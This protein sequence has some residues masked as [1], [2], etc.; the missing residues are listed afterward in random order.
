MIQSN[1]KNIE[2]NRLVKDLILVFI[3][4]FAASFGLK[5]FLLANNF[6]DGGATGISLLITEITGYPIYYLIFFVNIPF[7]VL[8]YF[9]IGRIFS[10]KTIIS[11]VLFSIVLAFVSFPV[12]TNDKLLVAIFGGFFLGAGIGFSIRGGA[13]LDGTEVLAIFLSRKFGLKIGDF[14]IILNLF[15]FI[16]AAYFL[17]IE[18]SLYSMITYLAASK[19]V[20]FVLEGFEEYIWFNIIT[21]EKEKMIDFIVNEMGYGVSIHEN[22]YGYGNSG[23][24][25]NVESIYTIV[26]RLEVNKLSQAVKQIDSSAFVIMHNVKDINGGKLKKR[27]LK[28]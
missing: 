2:L 25:E 23:R 3:G 10:I 12:I 4:I 24:S 1:L 9:V 16:C 27:K 6:I 26:T 19:T 7:I 20:D 18:S 8:A 14:I 28:H 15:I 22:F 13:V 17:G 5:G 21:S 11:I